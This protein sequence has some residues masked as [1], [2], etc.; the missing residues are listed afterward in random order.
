MYVAAAG[1]AVLAARPAGERG[2]RVRGRP[3]HDP[4][5]L[6]VADSLTV[7]VGR[8]QRGPKPSFAAIAASICGRPSGQPDTNDSPS[9][10]TL[11][12]T[13]ARPGEPVSV[14]RPGRPQAH[15]RVAVGLDVEDGQGGADLPVAAA[16]GV[17]ELLRRQEHLRI[18]EE[19]PGVHG[20][21]DP[22]SS[23]S[24]RSTSTPCARCCGAR[25]R[26]SGGG[27]STSTASGSKSALPDVV[28]DILA[29]VRGPKSLAVSGR[30][31]DGTILAEP[32]ARVRPGGARTHRS[33]PPAPPGHV[34]H[35]LGGR[36][37]GGSWPPRAPVSSGSASRTGTPTSPRS[38]RRGVGGAA[39]GVPDPG[40]VRPSAARCLGRAARRDGHAG[41]GPRPAGRTRCGGRHGRRPRPGR[42]RHRSGPWRR[43]PEWS[44]DGR[45]RLSFVSTSDRTGDIVSR[46]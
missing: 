17:Q 46:F 28:P 13:E 33:H 43:W 36:R 44:D 34:Q 5:D 2:A 1:R 42:T 27:T 29:G 26:R 31:A 8:R 35:R 11:E 20:R 38:V 7:E 40:G 19:H 3:R 25:D 24:W 45:T 21:R 22:A 6:L 37:S 30:V 39:G 14:F 15:H 41:G 12:S 18:P 32:V 10:G 16:A 4:G 23:P 9:A